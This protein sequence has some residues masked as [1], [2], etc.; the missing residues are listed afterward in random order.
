MKI[1]R[2]LLAVVCDWH[3]WS[4]GAPMRVCGLV[5]EWREHKEAVF[6]TEVRGVPADVLVFLQK[7]CPSYH[8]RKSAS[9]GCNYLGNGC[10][11]CGQLTGDFYLYS[12][13]DGPFPPRYAGD[14]G[15]QFD[16]VE[17][18][19][20]AAVDVQCGWVAGYAEEFLEGF[21]RRQGAVLGD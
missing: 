12:E 1:E 7:L 16:I 14:A 10:R 9:A 20:R 18:P 19:L 11:A 17:V 21:R 8:L 13:P 4:C 2:P 6:L 15:P 5:T 3:C